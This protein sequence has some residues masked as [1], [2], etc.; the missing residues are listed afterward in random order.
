MVSGQPSG[1]TGI[2]LHLV[3]PQPCRDSAP[4]VPLPRSLMSGKK[5]CDDCER[6]SPRMTTKTGLALCEP[7]YYA[8]LRRMAAGAEQ[9]RDGS[10]IGD[11]GN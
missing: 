7:C 5:Q 1:F 6:N 10:W 3:S 4:A 8:W 11:G 2:G 9:P